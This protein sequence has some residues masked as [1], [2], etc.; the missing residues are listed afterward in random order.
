MSKEVKHIGVNNLDI[1]NTDAR[2][3]GSDPFFLA[4]LALKKPLS[5]VLVHGR[6]LE[7]P[8]LAAYEPQSYAYTNSATRA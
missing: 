1:I 2:K 8:R 4:L 3:K 5:S 7:P 6:G